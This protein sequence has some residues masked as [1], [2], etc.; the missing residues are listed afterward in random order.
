MGMA[1]FGITN[2]A[3]IYETA[4]WR[5]QNMPPPLEAA[6]LGGRRLTRT[7]DQR[8]PAAL[9]LYGKRRVSQPAS[10]FL[11]SGRTASPAANWQTPRFA[12]PYRFA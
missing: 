10:R 1:P 7:A 2:T 11:F 9:R 4:A 6:T 12:V 5:Q 8:W 3:T